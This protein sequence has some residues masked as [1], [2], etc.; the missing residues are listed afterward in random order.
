MR[1]RIGTLTGLPA[2]ALL[3]VACTDGSAAATGDAP[4]PWVDRPAARY[5]PPPWKTPRPYPTT[6]SPCRARQLRVTGMQR[7][8]AAGTEAQRFVFTNVGP[9]TCLLG[10]YPQV[11]GELSSGVRAVLRIPH[12]P[13]GV[14]SAVV[15]AD[16][17]PGQ[18]GYL[19][20]GFSGACPVG[21]S[22]LARRVS[23]R[24]PGGGT[25]ATRYRMRHPCQGYAM[26][27]LGRFAPEPQPPRRDPGTPDVLEVRL[28]VKNM[29][30]VPT[31]RR[32]H[33]VVTLVNPRD[34]PVA[35]RPCPS[36]TEG[37]AAAPGNG[38]NASVQRSF[39]LNCDTIHVIG[40]YQR[41]RYRMELALGPAPTTLGKLYWHLN[42][43]NEP[44]A[45][46]VIAIDPAAGAGSG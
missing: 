3:V 32:L 9:T 39:F 36:Y 16:V 27:Q 40:P 13:G 28:S 19:D 10:G 46:A 29:A 5:T 35:L 17:P 25:V 7:E 1:L 42:S 12:R 43:P 2:F 15:P 34:V 8:A 38:L 30:R 14:F 18:H 6:A 21:R 4:V 31:S 22:V 20:L 23:F 41:V 24:L 11:T 45:V 37:V 33:Y 44:I 26:S